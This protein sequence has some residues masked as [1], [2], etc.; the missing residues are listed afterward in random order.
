[1][2]ASQPFNDFKMETAGA[3][4][5]LLAFWCRGNLRAASH[6]QSM[7][8]Q[9]KA[10]NPAKIRFHKCTF[11]SVYIFATFNQRLLQGV[12]GTLSD[13]L[14]SPGKSKPSI[15]FEAAAGSALIH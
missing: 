13:C 3:R 2:V 1:M 12:H 9:L 14:I 15:H 11:T 7:R 6:C 10:A 4:S 8:Q 5:P